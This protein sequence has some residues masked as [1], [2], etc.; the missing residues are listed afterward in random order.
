[1]LKA[2]LVIDGTWLYVN[3]MS[4][5]DE[6]HVE[7]D[8][9]GVLDFAKLRGVLAKAATAL[10]GDNLRIVRSHIFGSF[11]DNYDP[12]DENWVSRRLGLFRY[13]RENLG[14]DVEIYPV[15][16]R[17]NRLRRIDRGGT[18]FF[19]R[20]KCVDVALATSLVFN[21]TLPDF[22]D[23]AIV[24]V[25]DSDFV[26]ALRK[27]RSLGKQIIIAS[28]RGACSPIFHS[29]KHTL[30]NISNDRGWG[31][32]I[33]DYDVIWLNDYAEELRFVRYSEHFLDC[34]APQHKGDRRVLTT[35]Y[36][37]AGQRFY[38]KACRD[39]HVGSGEEA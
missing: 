23:V 6:R 13:L 15:D 32:A 3:N 20:E 22:F 35:F 28:I 39:D 31:G 29:E 12:R 18:D 37:K 2:Y 14:F 33:K 27:V 8:H 21:A 5:W 38:C 11:A 17:G 16:F 25:G 7:G 24:V 9:H 4:I 36:P 1:M 19:P 26:P 10:V 30:V 34:E